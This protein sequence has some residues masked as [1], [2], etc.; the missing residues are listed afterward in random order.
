MV[1]ALALIALTLFGFMCLMS[2]F[3]P[4]WALVLV[5]SFLAY[6]QLITSIVAPLAR[7]SWIIN[8]TAAGFAGLA[9]LSAMM[10]GR[11]PFRGLKNPNTFLI[12]FLYLFAYFG[13]TYSMAPDAAHYFVK[14][15]LPYMALMLVIFPQLVCSQEQIKRMC[16]PVLV[17]GCALMGLIF[18]SPRTQF[19]GSRMFIDLSYT[20]GGDSKGNPL[21]IAEFGGILVIVG[22]LMDQRAKNVLVSLLR[23]TAILLGIAIAF[24]VGSRGQLVFSVFVS[25]LFYPLAHE[26]KNIKQFFFRAASLGVFSLFL[27]ILAKTVLFASAAT[28]RFSSQDIADGINGRMYFY[29]ETL[30]AYFSRPGSFLQGIGTGSFNAVVP[31]GQE[32][33]LYPHNLVIE[34]LAHHG[35][36]GFSALMLIFL[37]T[38]VH[39]I[40]LIRAGFRGTVDRSV[41]AIVIALGVY[42]T[43]LAFK[44]GSFLII[45]FPFYMYL[46]ISKIYQR[47]V[48]DSRE[49]AYLYEEEADYGEYED[50]GYDQ[51]LEPAE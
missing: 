4:H 13:V 39:S 41:A 16:L 3:K 8:V 44:Q 9:L 51:E 33:F 34:V 31:H 43:M 26:I 38:M 42:M 27:F 18:I 24:L 46:V 29:T 47:M 17:I 19:Y 10:M 22:S 45:P 28:E 23:M 15:G 25:V 6:E 48:L 36:I 11:K 50:Y 20:V 12:A 5:F 49:S 1:T 2:L 7:R 30:N 21:A 14:T 40:G 37:F 35:L 32:G